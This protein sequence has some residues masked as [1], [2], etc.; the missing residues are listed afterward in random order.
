M[1]NSIF[2]IAILL[3]IPYFS[4][5]IISFILLLSQILVGKISGFNFSK[6]FKKKTCGFLLLQKRTNV[7]FINYVVSPAIKKRGKNIVGV[8]PY[9]VGRGNLTHALRVCTASAPVVEVIKY[10]VNG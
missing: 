7:F 6:N 4:P 2:I 5:F 9:F 3:E 1:W 8:N 10:P